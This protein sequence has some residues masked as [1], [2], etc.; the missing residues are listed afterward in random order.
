M[1]RTAPASFCCPATRRLRKLCNGA[2]Q[3]RSGSKNNGWS[4]P[5]ENMDHKIT[6]ETWMSECIQRGGIE[7]Y[8]ELHIDRIDS[9]WR[10]RATWISA[11]LEVLQ[12]AASIKDSAGYRELSVVLALSLQSTPQRK[13]VDFTSEGELEERLGHTPPSLYIFPEGKEPWF[14]QG[15]A[16]VTLKKIDTGIFDPSLRPKQCF[17]M[18][19][20]ETGE[21]DYQRSVFLTE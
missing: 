2:V 21:D 4:L 8:D 1:I 15:P 6:I 13:R 9:A 16:D 14:Q 18:E 10:K 7:R 3:K 20:K 11:S 12:L 17:Y 19:F 5:N